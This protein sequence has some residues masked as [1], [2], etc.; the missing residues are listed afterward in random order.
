MVAVMVLV[1]VFLIP[2]AFA[3]VFCLAGCGS[4]LLPRHS[5]CLLSRLLWR[6]WWYVVVVLVFFFLISSVFSSVFCFGLVVAPVVVVV[7]FFNVLSI[8][9]AGAA[10]DGGGCG[11]PLER[12]KCRGNLEQ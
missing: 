8:S 5:V 9:R 6:W 11:L 10:A 7:V 1:F 2:S 4:D 3:P 12:V